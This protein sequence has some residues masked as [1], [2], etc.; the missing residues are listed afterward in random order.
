MAAG[1]WTLNDQRGQWV[2]DCEWQVQ[3]HW[4]VNTEWPVLSTGGWGGG[5]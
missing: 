5:Q 4:W 3:W 1:G 2:G